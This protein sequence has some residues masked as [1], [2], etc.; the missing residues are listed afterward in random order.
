MRWSGLLLSAEPC[1]RLLIFCPPQ[2]CC[3]A[4]KRL[5]PCA[6][7]THEVAGREG[8]LALLQRGADGTLPNPLPY[9]LPPIRDSEQKP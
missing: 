5:L 9:F 3:A 2:A 4:S 8:L 6:Q 7:A 1:I